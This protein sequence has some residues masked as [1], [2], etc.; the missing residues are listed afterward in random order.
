MQ[1]ILGI[2]WV[3]SDG[4]D[5]LLR[6]F[7]PL[8]GQFVFDAAIEMVL[9]L[10]SQG[11]HG[12]CQQADHHNQRNNRVPAI[13][14]LHD[15]SSPLFGT[16]SP[17]ILPAGWSAPVPL[18]ATGVDQFRNAKNYRSLAEKQTHSK[19][20]KELRSGTHFTGLG[21]ETQGLW[22]AVD[23]YFLYKSDTIDFM[24]RGHAGKNF[25]QG[26]FAQ[27]G[28]PF[29]LCGATNFGTGT[30]LDDHLADVVAQ[31]EQ[32][33]NCG[34]AAIARVITAVAPYVRIKDSPVMLFG[35]Q[36]GFDQLGIG[37]TKSA[38]ANRAQHAHQTL[39]QHAVQGRN[40]VVGLDAHVE[41]TANHIDDVVGVDSG[42][43]QV[44]GQGRLD[45]DLRRLF[46]ADFADHYLVRVVAQ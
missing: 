14:C 1:L 18:H 25:L 42:E 35:A 30:P 31:I 10:L 7:L 40:K 45:R 23:V 26:R 15:F 34:P 3:G 21:A 6:R 43:Y 38:A 33:V 16:G 44:A 9:A 37:R 39:G 8:L 19:G 5:E 46:V 2:R 17:D 24:Q 20:S 4:Q 12:Q 32:F 13:Y 27:A 28:E 29:R 41:K 22:A 11:A 36:A